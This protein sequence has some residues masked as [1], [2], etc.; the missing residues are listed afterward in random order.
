MKKYL[1]ACAALLVFATVVRADPPKK[2]NLSYQS[3]TKK[4]KIEAIHPVKNVTE[5]YLDLISISVD[6]KEVKALK[7]KKQS[8]AAGENIE[9]VVPEIKAGS[10][11]EVKARCNEFGSKTAKLTIK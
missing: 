10:Q 6:G 4:L 11:V 1:V 3:E 9:I 8:S 2:V 5:H 7:P